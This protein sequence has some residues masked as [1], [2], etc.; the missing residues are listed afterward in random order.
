MDRFPVAAD[1]YSY[2]SGF[3]PP[4]H[5]GVDIMAP[6]HSRLVAVESGVAWSSTE[7]KG[8][9][10]VYLLGGS[11]TR[12]YYA[13]LEQLGGPWLIT[14]TAAN[15][16]PVKAGEDIGTIGTSGNA[17]GRPPHVHFQIRRGSDVVDP[18]PELFD[19][20]P[21]HRGVIPEPG[22]VDRFEAE[23]G[24]FGTGLSDT[25]TLLAVLWVVINASKGR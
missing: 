25:L 2:E 8:G 7:P 15:P 13:H 1:V 6:L 4:T 19:A 10:V 21:H 23:L 24:K 5:L 17:A 11:G 3:R 16:T 9:L 18:F 22:A 20:D 12:Y 14:A